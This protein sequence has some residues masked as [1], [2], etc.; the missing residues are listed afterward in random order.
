[1]RGRLGNWRQLDCWMSNFQLMCFFYE[2]GCLPLGPDVSLLF[3][4]REKRLLSFLGLSGS[5]SN[6]QTLCGNIMEVMEGQAGRDGVGKCK[7]YSCYVGGQ[8]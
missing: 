5:R 4:R 1:M 2:S 6:E 8:T 3:W 7:L